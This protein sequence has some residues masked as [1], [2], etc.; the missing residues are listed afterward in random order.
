MN[1]RGFDPAYPDADRAKEFIREWQE[2]DAKG[3]APQLLIV[4]LGGNAADSDRGIGMLVDAVSH[5]KLWASSAVFVMESNAPDRTP[6]WV[7]S[8]YT[9]RGTTDSTLYSQMSVL[10][11]VELIVGLRPMTQFDAAARAMFG[12]FSRTPDARP[13]SLVGPAK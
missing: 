4:R 12:S 10:R 9:H 5:S 6:V 3:Q 13:Y 1:Y 8:P 7:I 11:T 2:F